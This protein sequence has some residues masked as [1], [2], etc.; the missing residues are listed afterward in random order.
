MVPVMMAATT[1]PA[2]MPPM[3][4]LES[5]LL[6]LDGGFDADGLGSISSQ[7]RIIPGKME[8]KLTRR[9]GKGRIPEDR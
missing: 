9:K 1:A 3:A 7:E 2:A 8:I 6:E 5:P 4:P